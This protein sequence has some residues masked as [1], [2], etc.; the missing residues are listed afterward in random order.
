MSTL[1]PDPGGTV[2]GFGDILDALTYLLPPWALAVLGIVVAAI[3]IPRQIRA[4]R[5]RRLEGAIR[6][7]IRADPAL[8]AALTEDVWRIAGQDGWLL[9]DAVRT[10]R[11]RFLSTLADEALDRLR[12]VPGFHEEVRRLEEA[13]SRETAPAMHPVEAAVRV[14]NL[15]DTGALEAARLR[16]EEALVQHPQDAELLALREAV[17]EAAGAPVDVGQAE[18]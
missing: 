15:L 13:A 17:D 5:K 6:R 11:K 3:V 18:R 8:R 12:Q 7:M 4:M 2:R 14:R 1:P 9:A 16:L 10:F